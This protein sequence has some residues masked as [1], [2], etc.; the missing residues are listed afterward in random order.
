MR[1]S[2]LATEVLE[3]Y[4]QALM[5]LAQSQNLMEPFGENVNALLSLLRDSED[6]NQFLESP[7][8]PPDSKKAVLQ[9]VVGDQVH[10]YMKNFLM[11]LVDR[12][13]IQFLGGICKQYQALLRELN[14]T[15]LAEVTSTVELNDE[16]KQ[17]V[18]DRV[19]AMTKARQVDLDTKIDPELIGG[20]II[21][22]G[23]QIVDA[24]LRGQ[25]RR[26]SLRLSSAT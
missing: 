25:L 14:Q 9:Q 4:A 8:V 6:L 21:K 12:R 20:V 16:Q 26:I 18:R 2:V 5:S 1:D 11:L 10:P 23:S 19:I 24:S 13:R 22:V 7:L 3:P 15:V 17:T